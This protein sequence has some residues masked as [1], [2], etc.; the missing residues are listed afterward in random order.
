MVKSL[1][2]HFRVKNPKQDYCTNNYNI[3]GIQ[4]VGHQI[5]KTK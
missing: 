1:T 2:I 3:T 4:L 5:I